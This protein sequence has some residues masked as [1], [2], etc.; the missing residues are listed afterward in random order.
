MEAL[1]VSPD[2]VVA[3]LQ[4][5]NADVPPAASSAARARPGA[6][7]GAHRRARQFNDVVVAVRPGGTVRLSQV[8]RIEDSQEEERDVAYL[9]GGRAVA[10][11]VRKVSGGNTVDIADQVN[12]EVARLNASCRAA[13]R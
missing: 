13:R 2:M 9:E 8:A 10:I 4:R 5:E 11:E 1:G 6:H 12:A 7:Q 3:A